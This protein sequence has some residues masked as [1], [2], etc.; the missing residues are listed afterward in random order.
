M[1]RLTLKQ[2]LA[3]YPDALIFRMLDLQK[4]KDRHAI[5]KDLAGAYILYCHDSGKYYVGSSSNI[6]NRMDFYMPTDSIYRKRF[7]C[8]IIRALFKYGLSSFTLLVLPIPN[9]TRES[10]LKLEQ[11]L[12]DALSPE[13]N[14]LTTAGSGKGFK[15]NDDACL[16]ISEA[17]KGDK[18]PM[19]GRKGIDSPR[20]GTGKKLYVYSSLF[21]MM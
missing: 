16:K 14:I 10:L 8:V 6:A 11:E 9:S 13:Y 7:N 5:L 19:Y 12:I 18:N 3:L 4:R 2:I 15:H 20:Y 1:K 17:K 21:P